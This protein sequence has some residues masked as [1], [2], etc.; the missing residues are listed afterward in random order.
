VDLAVAYAA[1][2][3]TNLSYRKRLR[4]WREGIR[5]GEDPAAAARRCRVGGALAWAMDSRLNPGGSLDILEALE[6]LYRSHYTYSVALIRTVFWPCA[7]L[8]IG[9][10]VGA[11][12]LA[13]V[14][15]MAALVQHAEASM[16]P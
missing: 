3:D 7:T 15:S 5:A 16:V 2:M 13:V 9:L 4:R 14:G 1:G 6:R 12:A 10:M 11:L 8:A